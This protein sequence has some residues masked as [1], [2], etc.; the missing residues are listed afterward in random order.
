[1]HPRFGQILD[2]FSPAELDYLT[3]KIL[4]KIPDQQY[5]HKEIYNNGFTENDLIYPIIKKIVIEKINAVCP[6]K[7]RHIAVGMHLITKDPYGIHNDKHGK[8]D[9]GK[10]MA[11]LIPLWTKPAIGETKSRTIIFNESFSK[12]NRVPD[13]IASDPPK[14]IPDAG[15]IWEEIPQNLPIEWSQ[16]FSVGYVAE[17]YFGSLIYWDRDL[18]HCSDNFLEKGIKEKSALVIFASDD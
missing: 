6:F 8:G 9:A 17:W 2:V 7:I 11:Y 5:D 1:M 13:F 18:F 4:K 12:S 3:N 10:G 15:H 16:Y 14:K